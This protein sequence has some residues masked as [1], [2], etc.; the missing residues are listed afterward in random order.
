M[1][2][3]TKQAVS[4]VVELFDEDTT[5][6]LDTFVSKLGNIINMAEDILAP[7]C[8]A[9][10]CS[11]DG[12]VTKE[13]FRKWCV[14]FGPVGNS[15]DGAEIISKIQRDF[16]DS[17]VYFHGEVK[18][19]AAAKQVKNEHGKFL[20]RNSSKDGS[21]TVTRC[22]EKGGKLQVRHQ[23][24][25]NTYKGGWLDDA[26]KAT[27]DTLGAFCEANKSKLVKGI[28]R[29]SKTE[30]ET[31]YSANFTTKSNYGPAFTD[32]D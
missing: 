1:E 12:Q 24:L 10:L 8:E 4:M 25:T 29:K 11:A 16:A 27:Y 23:R 15:D 7:I 2:E 31:A 5:L 22:S 17:L 28:Q 18:A 19:E 20:Y 32:Q 3:A 13:A 6:D 26:G 21:F 30:G 9:M 14:D